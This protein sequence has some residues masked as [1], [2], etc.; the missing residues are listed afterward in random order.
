MAREHG[1]IGLLDKANAVGSKVVEGW[2]NPKTQAMKDELVAT[3]KRNP[4]GTALVWGMTVA[5]PIIGGFAVREARRGHWGTATFLLAVAAGTDFE[6]TPARLLE[7]TTAA[8]AVGDPFAD[9]GLR[10]E[11]LVAMAPELPVTT[12]IVAAAEMVNLGLNSKIQ[13]GREKPFV[14]RKAKWGSAAQA[15]GGISI[16]RGLDKDS[17]ALR[18]IGKATMLA[19]T[20]M[21]VHAYSR[22]YRRMKGGSNTSKA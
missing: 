17:V 15:A 7:V 12:G 14:P 6:G 22:E 3:A 5:R 1:P 4:G 9:G 21:R 18:T 19:G 13:K 16:F 2:N 10:G 8:G 11:A 20:A